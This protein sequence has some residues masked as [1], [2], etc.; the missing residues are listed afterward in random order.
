MPEMLLVPVFDEVAGAA[1]TPSG[2]FGLS[3]VPWFKMMQPSVDA[4]PVV[5]EPVT[6]LN[7]IEVAPE[8][9]VTIVG[10]VLPLPV[11]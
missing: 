4:H 10:A 7:T 3:P 1:P 11:S 6:L 5:M 8:G 2:S 9:K